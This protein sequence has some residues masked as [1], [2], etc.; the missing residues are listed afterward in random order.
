[1]VIYS[2]FFHE[3]WWFSIAMLVYQR[4]FT[5]PSFFSK[6]FWW[7]FQAQALA[8]KPAPHFWNAAGKLTRFFSQR[9][10]HRPKLD[11]W[12]S[13]GTLLVVL[14]VTATRHLDCLDILDLF[15]LMGVRHGKTMPFAPSHNHHQFIDVYRWYGYHSQY[16]PVIICC[17]WHCF[18][19]ITLFDSVWLGNGLWW[20]HWWDDGLKLPARTGSFPS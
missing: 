6:P 7:F 9:Y 12:G 1:M 17:L 2:E 4:V 11:R 20:S 19:H 18:T 13:R 14:D 10:G 15:D 8:A 16:F 5:I 3:K